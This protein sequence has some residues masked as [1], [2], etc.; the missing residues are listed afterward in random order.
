MLVDGHCRPVRNRLSASPNNAK[1]PVVDIDGFS[2]SSDGESDESECFS[3]D[4]MFLEQ[5]MNILTVSIK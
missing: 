4:N 2:L 3:W 5:Q 1:Q